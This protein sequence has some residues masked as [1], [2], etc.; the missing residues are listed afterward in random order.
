MLPSLPTELISNTFQYS[1]T[2]RDAAALSSTCRRLRLVFLSQLGPICWS[3]GLRT[4]YAFDIAL[5]AVRA[6]K[7]VSDALR[8]NQLPPAQSLYPIH[9][10]SGETRVPT[11]E[12][13]YEILNLQHFGTYYCHLPLAPA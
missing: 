8:V 6:T 10:L 4:L 9:Q 1:D 5:I 2:F 7:I 12:E 3:I 13:F 11:P